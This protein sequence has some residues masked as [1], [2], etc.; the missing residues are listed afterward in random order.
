MLNSIIRKFLV[1]MVV[2]WG[3]GRIRIVFDL[4]R[5]VD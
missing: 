2:V 1:R 5:K 3:M 4:G